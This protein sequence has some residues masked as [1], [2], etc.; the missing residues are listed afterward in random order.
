MPLLS[1]HKPVSSTPSDVECELFEACEAGDDDK[2]KKLLA[3]SDYA[4]ELLQDT[5]VPDRGKVI[6]E[7]TILAACLKGHLST[8][9]LLLDEGTNVNVSTD[10][11][12]PIYAASKIGNLKIVHVLIDWGAEF[13]HIRGGFSPLFAASLFGH[14]EVLKFLVR[15]AGISVLQLDSPQFLMNA[16]ANGHVEVVKWLLET[17]NFNLN[18]TLK[19]KDVM[20]EDKDSLLHV[21]CNQNQL[22]VAEFL[23]GQ[24]AIVT[25]GVVSRFPTI[26]Q[27]VLERQ[28]TEFK[29]VSS[30]RSKSPLQ[31]QANWS[32]MNLASLPGD[33]FTCFDKLAKVDL[34]QN[35]LESVP[36]SLFM[37]V[38]LQ[39]LDLSYNRL[40]ELTAE[41][42][43]WRC[44]Q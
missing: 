24:G 27:G 3:E 10:Q 1:H 6:G 13:R 34:K 14:M 18:K 43:M 37:L 31:F 22:E 28:I 25:K 4:V 44:D 41:E 12:T 39:V 36:E 42:C 33:V 21:A 30:T 5:H 29:P 7:R 9:K 32:D 17:T 19:G 11:G 40:S 16:C 2:L 38:S 26:I 20:K 8:V 35:M 23:I 15:R